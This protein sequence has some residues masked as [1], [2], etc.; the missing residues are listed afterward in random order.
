MRPRSTKAT[1]GG[2]GEVLE[3]L[4]VPHSDW[5]ERNTILAATA[6]RGRDATSEAARKLEECLTMRQDS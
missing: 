5:V 3:V 1:A 4:Q 2:E 6:M